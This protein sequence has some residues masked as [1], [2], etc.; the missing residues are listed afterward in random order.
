MYA[1]T[2]I[3]LMSCKGGRNFSIKVLNHLNRFLKEDNFS[4]ISLTDT[5]EVQFKHRNKI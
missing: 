4:P 5:E 2:K 1:Q 3:S